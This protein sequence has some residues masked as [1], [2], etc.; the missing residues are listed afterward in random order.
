MNPILITI[1]PGELIDRISI[2]Q[3]KLRHATNPSHKT[4]LQHD[5]D[6]LLA[7]RERL[8]S[9]DELER[10]ARELAHVNAQ[11]W[12]A[13][14]AIRSCEARGDFGPDFVQIARSIYRFNDRR[15]ELRR[16]I[17]R[18]LNASSHDLKLYASK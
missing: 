8:G 11:L 16:Q 1:S 7:A 3:L 4:A 10:L 14:D 2:L 15:C 5:L 13:E 12:Q 18:L 17:D 9:S 6:T